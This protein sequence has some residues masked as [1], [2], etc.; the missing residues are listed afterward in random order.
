MDFQLLSIAFP[1]GGWIPETYTGE[2]SDVSPALEW[3]GAPEGTRSF[4]LVMDDPDAPS[5]VFTHWL[6]YDMAP[7]ITR[8]PQAYEPR[9]RVHTGTNSFGRKGYNGPMP[10]KGDGPH[11]YFFRVYALDKQT[12]GLPAGVRAA[13]LTAAMQPHVL[14]EASYMGQFERVAA[15]TAQTERF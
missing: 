2:G 9:G 1:N 8:L 13:E 6:L 7:D 12:L 5:G 11:R 15:R 14:A 4:A 10:P 3:S